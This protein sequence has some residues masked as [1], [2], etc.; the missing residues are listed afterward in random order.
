MSYGPYCRLECAG[1]SKDDAVRQ[2]G[3]REICGRA[4]PRN[5]AHPS[6]KAYPRPLHAGE[7]GIAFT[8][9]VAPDA[10]FSAPH[11]ARWYFPHTP[12]V[13]QRI[14]AAGA[15]IVASPAAVTNLQP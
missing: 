7:R 4:H 9:P 8:T 12:G 5:P 1:Q 2:V 15:Q 10:R 13:A 14:D 6:I 3:S 11:E